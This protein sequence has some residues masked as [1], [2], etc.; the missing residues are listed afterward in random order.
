MTVF[1]LYCPI[2]KGIAMPTY[3]IVQ[4]YACSVPSLQ[5][6]YFDSVKT[7]VYVIRQNLASLKPGINTKFTQFSEIRLNIS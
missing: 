1:C 2:T 4:M 3:Q 6:A 7:Q 5:G